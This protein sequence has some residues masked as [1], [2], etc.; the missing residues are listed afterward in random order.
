MDDR[1]L[2]YRILRRYI[3]EIIEAKD[4][5]YKKLFTLS[6]FAELE[7][8]YIPEEQIK[9]V[10]KLDSLIAFALKK[11]GH[12]HH[13][14][15]VRNNSS[16]DKFNPAYVFSWDQAKLVA[17]IFVDIVSN[18]ANIHAL[19]FLVE[20]FLRVNDTNNSY[21]AKEEAR[22]ILGTLLKT[23]DDP[24][25]ELVAKKGK[26]ILEDIMEQIDAAIRK[27][28][29][30]FV[31]G[32][33]HSGKKIMVDYIINN[34]FNHVDIVFNIRIDCEKTEVTYSKFLKT[35]WSVFNNNAEYTK[36]ES[37]LIYKVQ[38]CITDDV[39][40]IVFINGFDCI[41]NPDDQKNIISFL[42]KNI[43][44][45]DIVILTSTEK[46]DKYKYISDLFTSIDVR[47]YTKE[48]W[49]KLASFYKSRN[50]IARDAEE[51]YEKIAELAFML[52][53]GNPK[54]LMKCFFDL[55]NQI[56]YEDTTDFNPETNKVLFKEVIKDLNDDCIACLVTLSLFSNPISY[57]LLSKISGIKNDWLSNA[58][59]VLK[60]KLLIKITE[61]DSDQKDFLYSLPNKL[62]VPM[63]D[64]KH[65]HSKKYE[66]IFE[67]WIQY[68][69]QFE[70]INEI[71]VEDENEQEKL[72]MIFM[73]I[74]RILDYCEET[75]RWE[76]YCVLSQLLW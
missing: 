72:K 66:K 61:T 10:K 48:D 38:E 55:C 16:I 12:K 3:F 30:V 32:E 76:D 22:K 6:E 9:S 62:K 15:T 49:L 75:E 24:N 26:P 51:I 33:K 20:D 64:E 7:N 58:I 29:F 13:F 35:L 4:I 1:Q 17:K 2:F 44:N 28:S 65:N 21:N 5:R 34:W 70:N 67:R 47:K 8:R 60:D 50:K 41:K 11:S 54:K 25:S 23:E 19:E 45:D 57:S 14:E 37:E 39:K 73:N 46:K 27:K 43:P 74:G 53:D 52:G 40:F 59:N 69:K 68:F 56:A 36:S 71:S 42:E 31:Q 18:N 63:D